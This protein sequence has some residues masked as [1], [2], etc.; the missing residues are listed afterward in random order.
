MCLGG[1]RCSAMLRCSSFE[2]LKNASG[3][4]KQFLSDECEAFFQTWGFLNSNFHLDTAH[5]ISCF[6]SDLLVQRNVRIYMYIFET[7]EKMF[8]KP[9]QNK[10]KH[11]A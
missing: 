5:T 10:Q 2:N 11:K 6:V 3:P 7:K 9:K 4:V 1:L 8:L